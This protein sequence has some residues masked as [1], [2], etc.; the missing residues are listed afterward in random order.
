MPETRSINQNIPP[1]LLPD[2]R[3]M[4]TVLRIVLLTNAIALLGALSQAVS[5]ADLQS[6]LLQGS[7]LL[8]PVL[9]TSL[10]LLY[11]LNPLFARV[12]YWQGAT[13]A[14][15]VV[16]VAAVMVS[17]L[18]R[19]ILFAPDDTGDFRYVRH[20]LVGA[21]VALLLLA[22]F[23]LRALALAPAKHEARLQALQARI[24][25]HFLFNTI[26]AVLSIVRADPKRAETALED[27]ADLF[28][29]AMTEPREL[30]A[31]DKEVELARQY[32]AI[33]ELRLG[34]RL[35]VHW[36]TGDMPPDALIPPLIL[37]PLLENAVYHGVEPLQQGGTIE[38]R[39]YRA[40]DELHL[41]VRNPSQGQASLHP[42]GNRMALS[43]IRE[44]LSLLF[45]VEAQYQVE[46]DAAHY[47]VHIIIPYVKGQ[48]A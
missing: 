22:Y 30:V 3:N 21:A 33:E 47:Q 14:A 44:R 29:M 8:Q 48:P 36:D 42:N 11:S 27:M 38:V 13:V 2:F 41:E 4:G 45:D 43:N 1:K 12:P 10:L 26:N 25:P 20:A 37:Q 23:R 6:S 24:R 15:A 5:L 19:E 39:L 7:A 31:L 18:G 28:R 34:E 46:H 35:K 17:M 32:L 16:A 9:L 40:R